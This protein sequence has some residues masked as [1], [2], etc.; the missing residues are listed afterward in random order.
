MSCTDK[1]PPTTKLC[2]TDSTRRYWPI[3]AFLSARDLHL[4]AVQL[5]ANLIRTEGTSVSLRLAFRV[6]ND[7]NNLGSYALIGNSITN[8]G[9][10]VHTESVFTA[11]TD[12]LCIQFAS[13]GESNGAGQAEV[14]TF[15]QS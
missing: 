5:Y 2:N 1:T 3:T 14:T 9:D 6:A 8:L 15:T 10:V 12:K 13:S 7:L 4:D 11:A